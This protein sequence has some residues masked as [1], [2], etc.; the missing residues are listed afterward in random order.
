MDFA[1]LANWRLEGRLIRRCLWTGAVTP[2]CWNGDSRL[3]SSYDL[4]ALGRRRQRFHV[5]GSTIYRVALGEDRQPDAW[6][7]ALTSYVWLGVLITATG[8]G[9]TAAVTLG[10]AAHRL[11]DPQTAPRRLIWCLPM[12]TLVDTKCAPAAGSGLVGAKE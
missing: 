11:R 4:V 2:C 12:R 3:R 6:Q 5:Y 1:T 9:K 8:S 10:W 7:L